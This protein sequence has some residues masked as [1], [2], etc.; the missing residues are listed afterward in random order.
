MTCL[1]AR[2][3]SAE[4]AQKAVLS[5]STSGLGAIFWNGHL[6]ARDTLATGVFVDEVATTVA[7]RARA[8]WNSLLI[9]TSH[10]E[11]P[12]ATVWAILAAVYKADGVTALDIEVDRSCS[13]A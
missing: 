4:E 13:S 3:P 5:V 11:Q 8:G 2:G 10:N 7:L 12:G 1:R 6:V 9:K